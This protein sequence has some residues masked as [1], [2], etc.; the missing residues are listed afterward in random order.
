MSVN[1][2]S[3]VGEIKLCDGCGKLYWEDPD[4]KYAGPHYQLI[5][6]EGS[7]GEGESTDEGA[8]RQ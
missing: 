5:R 6:E 7:G 3:R 4:G 8:R 1:E 2:F